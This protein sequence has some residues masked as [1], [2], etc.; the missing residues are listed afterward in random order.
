MKQ[1][2]SEPSTFDNPPAAQ[3]A[4]SKAWMQRW[5]KVVLK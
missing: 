2:A 4:Q 3:M 5:T 1:H